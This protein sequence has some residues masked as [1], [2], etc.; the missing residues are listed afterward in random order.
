M[1]P[2]SVLGYSV[3]KKYQGC[4]MYS[5][6][7]TFAWIY[8]QHWTDYSVDV[9]PTLTPLLLEG[10][11]AGAH[12]LD[13]CCGTGQ[14]ARQLTTRGFRVTGVDGSAEMLAY[15][16]ENAPTATFI[17]ADARDFVLPE[18]VDAVVSLFDSLNHITER[19]GL[20]AAFRASY[21]ALRPGGLFVFDL[22]MDAIYLRDWRGSY[23]IVE[24]DHVV[25]VR[26]KYSRIAR[27]AEMALTILREVNGVYQRSDLT[28]IERAYPAEEVLEALAGAGFVDAKGYDAE[29]DLAWRGYAGRSFFVARKP[30][31]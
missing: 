19:A 8:N 11:P 29:H 24:S 9:M 30:A 16:R 17:Q 12:I 15:A 28:L 23:S 2:M 25:A 22:N 10:L 6:Y 13:L 20:E 14:L 1:M 21:A 18:P 3:G 7:D 26:S 27:Q 31:V 5:T 4:L